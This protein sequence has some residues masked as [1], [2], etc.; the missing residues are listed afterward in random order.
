MTGAHYNGSQQLAHREAKN[1]PV[2]TLRI[3]STQRQSFVL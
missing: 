2:A 1:G 3:S